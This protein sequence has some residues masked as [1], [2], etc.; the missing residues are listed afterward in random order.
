MPESRWLLEPKKYTGERTI[1]SVRM[2]RDMLSDLDALAEK[3][4]RTRNEVM[5]LA[6][7]FAIEHLELGTAETD[8]NQK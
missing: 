1:V 7:E 5:T 6:L 4:G 3:T 2:P 8:N